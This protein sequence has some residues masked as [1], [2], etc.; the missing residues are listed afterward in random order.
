MGQA[1]NEMLDRVR[2]KL[3][4]KKGGKFKADPT[5]WKPPQVG[6]KDTEKNFKFIVLPP[7][8][9]GDPVWTEAGPGT[10]KSTTN[11]GDLYYYQEGKHWID[12][13][14][15]ECPRILDESECEVCQLGFDLM[16]ETTDKE[17]RSRIARQY[18]SRA[19]Q[20]VNV[21]FPELASNPEELR[22]QV[23]WIEISQRDIWERFSECINRDEEEAVGDTPEEA[24]AH[25]FFYLPDQCYI[26]NLNVKHK[27]GYND[28]GDSKFLPSTR[29][30]IAMKKG[31]NEPDVE[32]IRLIMN[33]RHDLK[34][35]FPACDKAKIA[36][37]AKKLMD[38]GSGTEASGGWDNAEAAPATSSTAPATT[39]VVSA[40]TTVTTP[41]TPAAV[42]AAAAPATAVAEAKSEAVD[43]ELQRLLDEISHKS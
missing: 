16:S 13:R 19:S 3:L 5:S 36:E 2:K 38:V 41:A 21:Y 29:G 20:V 43:P 26:F 8:A 30:Y 15:H 33:S 14:P 34:S 9:E 10:G 22:G 23:R 17:T 35:K 7:L 11:M 24:K 27:N 18:L 25:G 28:Y 42:P 6:P 32:K 39:T 37:I 31:T 40:P 12:K 4:E 1:K